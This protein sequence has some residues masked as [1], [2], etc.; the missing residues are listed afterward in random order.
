M[1]LNMLIR[2]VKY[3]ECNYYVFVILKLKLHYQCLII[4]SLLR[5]RQVKIA[6]K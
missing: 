6:V 3:L 5:L 1:S 2:I 4:I